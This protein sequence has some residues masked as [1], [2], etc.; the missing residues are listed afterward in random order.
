MT[1][2]T[3]RPEIKGTFGVVTSTHWIASA[4]G[5]SI[6][7]RGGN[8]FDAAVA[9]GF[10][11]QVVEPHLNGPAGDLPVIYRKAGEEPAVLC[12][13]GP[14]PA[15]ATLEAMKALGLDMIP[16]SGLLATVVPGAFDGWLTLLRDQG[17]MELADV[18]APAIDYL[19]NGFPTLA[20]VSGA[21]RELLPFFQAH[22]PSSAEVWAPGG[23]VP[24]PDS[25]MR[26][27]EL[28]QTWKRICSLALGDTREER[29][30]AARKAWSD[31]FVADTIAA[32]LKD[33]RV[34]DVT[35]KKHSAFLSR[36]DIKNWKA[37]VEAPVSIGYE[38]WRI[39]KTGPWG[40]GPVLLQALQILKNFDL[41]A[42]DPMGLEFV[43]VVVEAIKLAWADREAYYGDPD[44]FDIPIEKLLSEDYGRERAKLIG[45]RSSSEQRPGTIRGYEALV[46][47]AI[48]RASRRVEIEDNPATG[49]PT[50]AHLTDVRGDTVHV[51]IIDREGNLVSATPSGGWLQSNP[52]VP[53]L[54]FALNSRAQMFWLDDGLA[55]T[56]RPGAR[57]RT[58]L[59]PSLALHE[60]G[61]ALAFGTPGGDQQDQWQLI[62]FLRY[63]HHGLD[64]QAG[65]DAPLFHSQHFQGS[66]Y[67]RHANPGRLMLEA[68][69]GEDVISQL[70]ERGHH[71]VVSGPN[72]IGR[73]TA[74]LRHPNGLLQAA[75]TPRLMQAYAIGR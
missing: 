27:P 41:S 30:D 71:V 14:A 37:R 60:D 18:L 6:L 46:E 57:P 16:G 3:T 74:A 61:R 43:H 55:S 5:M 9:T 62:W 75:A 34:M 15:A 67:P 31:G 52:V 56:L 38:G 40:Q 68:S 45:E 29:I 22:W 17:T 23:E 7:E 72:T 58:T 32:W 70:K 10:V 24:Q 13:Q 48:A 28:A 53:G 64:L 19:E 20:A 1:M 69:F 25:L 39:Y 35:G 47:A 33:A 11:L 36:D 21:I 66:F 51:D 73:L 8:A 59:T 63:V 50:M 4:V 26:N 42:M 49:E 54:G 44:F 65:I 12:A 2:F